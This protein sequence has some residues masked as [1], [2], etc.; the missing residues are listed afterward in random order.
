MAQLKP[1]FFRKKF[2]FFLI[3]LFIYFWLCWVFGAVKAFI[4]LWRLGLLSTAVFRL[5]VVALLVV[6]HKL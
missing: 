6:E 2:K 4:Y 1:N 3:S 5:P